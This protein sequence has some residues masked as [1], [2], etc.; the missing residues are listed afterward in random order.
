ML[1]WIVKKFVLGKVN[2]ALDANQNTV[3]TT[4]ATVIVWVAR[5][6]KIISCLKSLLSKLDDG[7]IDSD[8]LDQAASEIQKVIK[9]W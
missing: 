6:E 7:K 4:K 9:E 3:A 5:L 2:D 8:E 1:K